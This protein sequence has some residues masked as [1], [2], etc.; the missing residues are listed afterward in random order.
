MKTIELTNSLAEQCSG[1]LVDVLRDPSDGRVRA[2]CLPS[3]ELFSR[4]IPL[5]HFSSVA[6]ILGSSGL[7][8]VVSMK[9]LPWTEN[10]VSKVD[11][12]LMCQ[13][14]T[15]SWP[16]LETA[17]G[18]Y[19]EHSVVLH[20]VCLL[21]EHRSL[22][23]IPGLA[24]AI[25][26]RWMSVQ[27]ALPG[28]VELRSMKSDLIREIH[29]SAD[30]ALAQFA[31]HFE[32]DLAS[33][34]GPIG[35]RLDK[36]NYLSHPNH[37]RARLQFA[38]AFPL[39]AD[40]VCSA[41]MN[42]LW[43]ALGRK[44]DDLRSPVLFLSEALEVSPVSVRALNGVS[45]NDVGQYFFEHTTELISIL[46]AFPK[47]F[48]PKLPE[49]WQALQQQFDISKQFFG[50]S[51]A[52]L[53]LVK[54]RV[55]S[56]RFGIQFNQPVVHLDAENIH[57]VERLRSGLIQAT[58]SYYG[59]DKNQVFGI[60]RRAKISQRIDRFL[61][62]LSWSRLLAFS[63]KFEK[64]YAETVEKNSDSIKFISE[65]KY[66]NFCPDGKFV[67]A[68][69]WSV[70][71]LSSS[72][73]L[74]SHGLQLGVCLATAG[75]RAVFH[76]A[77]YLGKATIFAIHDKLGEVRSTAEFR[78]TMGKTTTSESVI[79]F[80]LVQHTGKKNQPVGIAEKEA[81]ESLRTLFSSAV[82]QA[83]ARNGMRSI[84]LRN[85]YS[86][87][88][89]GVSAALFM[90]SLLAFRTTFK[91]KSSELLKQFSGEQE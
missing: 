12:F 80:Q 89:S 26:R 10:L 71:C 73:E 44:V 32:P 7:I 27:S 81:L 56:L 85:T 62:R 50:R 31:S 75:Y 64:C 49:H 30:Q 11:E 90:T 40:L 38:K 5:R 42:S 79:R 86:N 48:L 9:S 78:L 4:P 19:I 57:K 13:F 70:H 83:H 36:Y 3:F 45:T 61:G 51:P 29:F 82:W 25:I 76:E 55:A 91:D 53:S 43:S 16:H 22:L 60:Q 77:C 74:K 35:V 8:W 14:G 87:Q 41:D 67:T 21:D 2:V 54:S 20:K 65:Q 17:L 1:V 33:V 18:E 6:L 46:D 15:L 39:L 88:D 28:I 34:S 58:Y 37:Q 59:I 63:R 68:G 52:A 69:G 47:E 84:N 72:E 23:Q 24:D 66:Y